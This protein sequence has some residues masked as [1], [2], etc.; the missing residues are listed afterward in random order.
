MQRGQLRDAAVF[1]Q[2]LDIRHLPG[3]H[4]RVDD[5]PV[6]GIP[7]DQKSL[8]WGGVGHVSFYIETN[9]YRD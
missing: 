9:L 6:G 3:V 2:P 1:D 8:T 7:A 5:F 4:Q